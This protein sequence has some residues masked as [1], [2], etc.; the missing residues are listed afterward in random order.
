MA[1]GAYLKA[2]GGEGEGAVGAA[3]E[4]MVEWGGG[5]EAGW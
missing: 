2:A 1:S 4:A 3:G 5:T